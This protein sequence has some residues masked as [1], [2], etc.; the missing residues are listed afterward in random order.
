MYQAFWE[1]IDGE[2]NKHK[3]KLCT[4]AGTDL[5]RV[6]SIRHGYGNL[7]EHILTKHKSELEACRKSEAGPMDSHVLKLPANKNCAAIRE[8]ERH[9]MVFTF[10]HVTKM[11]TYKIASCGNRWIL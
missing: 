1:P 5:I 7:V 4:A 9:Q 8:D 6:Q 3:C 2:P 11:A 10:Q